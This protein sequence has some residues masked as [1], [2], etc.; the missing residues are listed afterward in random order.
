LSRSRIDGRSL[1][2][3]RLLLVSSFII[4]GAVP[5]STAT[6]FSPSLPAD[7]SESSSLDVAPESGA[8][9]SFGASSARSTFTNTSHS[10]R[11][12]SAPGDA[13]SLSRTTDFSPTPVAIVCTFNLALSG[14]GPGR[15][16]PQV[17]R[18]GS[19]FSTSNVDESDAHT[20]A[21][22]GIDP[23]PEGEFRVRDLVAGRSSPTCAGTQAITWA[24]NHSGR[25]LSYPGPDGAAES[26]ANN[27]MDVWVGRTKVFDDIAVTNPMI[28]ITDL[29]WFWGSGSGSGTTSFGCFQVA[30]LPALS[31]EK[32]MAPSQA[33][34]A[35]EPSPDVA[36]ASPSGSLELYRPTPNPFARA[37]RFAYSIEGHSQPAEIGMYDVAGRRI[38]TF[39]AGVQAVGRYEVS[40]D[41]R[42]DDGVRARAGVYFLR[43]AVGSTTRVVRVVYLL[44]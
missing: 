19:G 39:V 18:F 7:D 17:L 24:L 4:L 36:V 22:L 32:G 43:A 16:A 37:M 20:Y 42:A 31:D 38:R 13:V 33:A 8:W 23:G 11:I 27:R 44:N 40:W 12:S 10:M 5:A 1:T 9:D 35:A 29:K 2:L 6:I 21:R 30:T 14:L 26:I 15:P 28:S 41:G 3:A 34:V 25:A